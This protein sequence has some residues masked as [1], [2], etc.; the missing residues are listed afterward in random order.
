MRK[1]DL[2]AHV[3]SR[4]ECVDLYL[5]FTI[6]LDGLHGDY[7]IHAICVRYCLQVS[8]YNYDNSARLRGN[9]LTCSSCRPV[10]MLITIGESE[11]YILIL[12]VDAANLQNRE[13]RTRG[14]LDLCGIV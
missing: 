6:R 13:V 12:R 8:I 9:A 4:L 1:S 5:P 11:C 14:K 7:F 2:S 10:S 3:V